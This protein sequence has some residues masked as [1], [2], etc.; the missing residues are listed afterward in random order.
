[1]RWTRLHSALANTSVAGGGTEFTTNN[2]NLNNTA[3]TFVSGNAAGT[4]T[5]N[6]NIAT[7]TG[8][9]AVAAVVDGSLAGI[10]GANAVDQLN[11]QLATYGISASI[12]NDGTLQ[13][14][15][16][17]AFTVTAGALANGATA[18]AVATPAS[19]AINT[20]NYT[21]D[22]ATAD[23]CRR[24]CRAGLSSA[25]RLRARVRN[26][27]RSRTPMGRPR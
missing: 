13:F 4:Q 22:S 24:H 15:G 12:A 11:S 26:P 8:N 25:L 20:S 23:Q 10:T 2:V 17:T 16:S 7:A 3:T 19:T 5:F 14:G 1:M 18:G 6:F 9:T 27:F 21:V